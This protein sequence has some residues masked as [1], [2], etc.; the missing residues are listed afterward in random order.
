MLHV[1]SQTWSNQL[2]HNSPCISQLS[3]TVTKYPRFS[4]LKKRK[5]LFRLSVWAVSVC[6]HLVRWHVGLSSLSR[7]LS[8]PTNQTNLSNMNSVTNITERPRLFTQ[9]TP[10]LAPPP[11]QLATAHAQPAKS[12][13]THLFKVYLSDRINLSFEVKKVSVVYMLMSVPSFWQQSFWLWCC[14]MCLSLISS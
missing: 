10:A 13:N 4:A 9:S 12:Y 3:V 2:F 14:L 1:Q 7:L 5:G 8:Y 6:C 11:P